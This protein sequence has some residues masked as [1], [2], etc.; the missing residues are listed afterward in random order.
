MACA[1]WDHASSTFSRVGVTTSATVDTVICETTHLT[2]FQLIPSADGVV[3]EG[4][5][6]ELWLILEILL[7]LCLVL[8]LIALL[9]DFSKRCGC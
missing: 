2:A 8:V 3:T 6:G 4:R 5:D 7:L 9:V 1:F